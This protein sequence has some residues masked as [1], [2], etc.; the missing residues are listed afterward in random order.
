VSAAPVAPVVVT[1]ENC[2]AALGLEPRRF[3][4]LIHERQIQHTK[5]GKLRL[6][7]VEHLL[8]A[9]EAEPAPKRN[10]ESQSERLGRSAGLA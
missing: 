1:Q 10:E 3:L 4:A 2:L 9:I 5:L 8:E 6:V 7:R